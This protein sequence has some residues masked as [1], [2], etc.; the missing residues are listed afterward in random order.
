MC[1]EKFEIDPALFTTGLIW[2]AA[3]KKLELLSNIDMLFNGKRSCQRWI[4]YDLRWYVKANTKY[5][6]YY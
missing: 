5:K 1:Y 2:Q 4:R 3:F 6:K